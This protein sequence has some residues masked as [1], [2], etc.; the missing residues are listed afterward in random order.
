MKYIATAHEAEEN[1]AVQMRSLGFSD[2]RV[3]A[4]GADG[5]I[6]VRASGAIAQVKWR[7]GQVG[8]PELQRLFGARGKKFEL[9][10]FFFAASPYSTHAVSYA[11]EV[12]MALYTYDPTGRITAVN[13][14]AKR[15]AVRACAPAVDAPS[16]PASETRPRASAVASRQREQAAQRKIALAKAREQ[17]K[18]ARST[19]IRPPASVAASRARG[20]AAQ[21]KA[22]LAKA[23]ERWKGARGTNLAAH[24]TGNSGLDSSNRLLPAKPYVVQAR[25]SREQ[26]QA[27][28]VQKMLTLANTRR[29]MQAAVAANRN[30]MTATNSTDKRPSQPARRQA[31]RLVLSIVFAG[32]ASVFGT[33]VFA[34][35]VRADSS[36]RATFVVLAVMFTVIAWRQ[37]SKYRSADQRATK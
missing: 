36:A 27:Q 8:R 5:G 19:E 15:I 7:A 18:A 1:A 25:S 16:R 11:N 17:P 35:Q 10:L 12:D 23:R 9:L 26:Q 28:A 32:V 14:V 37:F 22:D 20:Q 2:A 3:T 21:R 13:A 6:D 30:G 34:E 4:S 24:L 33:A 29:R 31:H